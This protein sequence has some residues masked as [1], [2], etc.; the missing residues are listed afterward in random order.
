MAQKVIARF[1]VDQAGEMTEQGRKEV[2]DWLRHQAEALEEEG[3]NYSTNH[4][5]RY[6]CEVR[7]PTQEEMNLG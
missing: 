7:D 3:H 6:I 2:A 5:A 1:V 4:V